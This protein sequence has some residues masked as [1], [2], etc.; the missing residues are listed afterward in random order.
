MFAQ[1][2]FRNILFDLD[3]EKSQRLQL[4]ETTH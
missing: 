4:F 3:D 1:A 2:D